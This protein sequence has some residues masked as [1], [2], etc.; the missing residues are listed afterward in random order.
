MS[1]D[2]EFLGLTGAET[3]PG[4]YR[5]T[6]TE[7]LSR[8]DGFLYGGTAIAVS[9]AAAELVSERNT[10]WMTT[11]FVSSVAKGSNVSVHAEVL[12]EGKRTNQVR[13]TATS[14]NGDIVFA[15]LG[16]TGSARPDALNGVFERPPQVPGPLR[17]GDGGSPFRSMRK[18]AGLGDDAPPM[19]LAGFMLA[20][21]MQMASEFEDES[22]LCVWARRRDGAPITPAIAAFLADLVPMG[23]SHGLGVMAAATSLDN[24]IRI[25]TFTDPEWVLLQIEPH[26]V[27]NSYG[28][29]AAHVWDPDG[30]LLATASQSASMFTFDP[31]NLVWDA[32]PGA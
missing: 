12:A 26:F 16:A 9:V 8:P 21:E 22:G 13:V 19:P 6:V 2:V 11:Q 29:G 30:N 15:S 14:D 17:D 7:V 27:S 20:S 32:S 24:T 18:A 23:V 28:H 4:R 31:T 3:G 25:G 1:S 5:F 10:V